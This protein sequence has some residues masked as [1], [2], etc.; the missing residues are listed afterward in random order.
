VSLSTRDNI[1]RIIKEFDYHPN[2]LASALASQ[3][4]NLFA[5]LLP[6]ALS[7]EAYWSRPLSGISKSISA[8]HQY[9]VELNQH[10]FDMEDASTFTNEANK[11]LEEKPDGVLLAP[12]ARREASLFVKELDSKNIPYVFIDSNI[13][14]SSPVSFIGQD[15]FQSGYLSAKLLNFG[16]P[17]E[18]TILIVHIA[19]EL[20]NQNHL[21]QREEGFLS[22][23]RDCGGSGKRI[24]KIELDSSVDELETKLLENGLSICDINGV[25][26]T[27]SK[28]HIVARFFS[29]QKSAPTI[30]GYDLIPDNIKLIKS[31]AIDFLICQKP[32]KQ[33]YKAISVLFDHVVRKKY[34]KP[35]NYTSID[36]I[37][38]ENL[39]YYLLM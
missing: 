21:L 29:E 31:D 34:V 6:K 35:E 38:K 4:T 30:I 17:A 18:S 28:V 33:G 7:T 36:I 14:D 12:W 32:E 37:A 39:E 15:S 27:N 8:L 16:S 19:K 23:F 1:L 26:V 22:Y 24:V 5:T 25:F 3:K 10:F 13:S 2:I 20:D 11:I 9:G